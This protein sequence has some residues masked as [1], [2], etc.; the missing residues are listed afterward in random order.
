MFDNPSYWYNN[1]SSSS[2]LPPTAVKKN[3]R[4]SKKWK[5]AMLDGLERIALD[6]FEQNQIFVDYYRMIDGE[7]SFQELKEAIPQLSD[8][9]DLLDGVG[10]PTFLKHYDLIGIIVN[11]LVGILIDQKDI[12]HVIDTGEIAESEYIREKTKKL[13]GLITEKIQAGVNLAMAEAG[14]NPDKADFQSEEEQQQYIAQMQQII[15]GATPKDLQEELNKK[16]KTKGVQWANVTLDQDEEKFDLD[17]LDKDNFKDMLLTGRCFRN[18]KVNFDSYYPE[19]WD[20]INTFF[21]QTID[22]TYPQKGEYIGRLHFFSPTDV[23]NRYGEYLDSKIQEELLSGN[24]DWKNFVTDVNPGGISNAIKSNF[25]TRY[26]VPHANYF[27]YTYALNLQDNLDTPLGVYTDYKTGKESNRFLPNRYTDSNYIDSRRQQSLRRDVNLREDLCQVLEAYIIVYELVGFLTYE[28]E[29]GGVETAEVDEDILPDFL[30]DNNIKQSYKETLMDIQ[31][32]FEVNTLKWYY[33]PV[34]YEG[35]KIKSSN[36]KEDLYVYFKPC[37]YQ[38]KGDS[39]MFEVMLPVSGYVGKS[40]AKKIAPYQAGYNLAM[41]QTYSLMEKEMGKLFLLDI[42][43]IPS[44]FEQWGDSEE[45]LVHLRNIAKDVGIMPIATSGDSRKSQNTFNQFSTYDLTN[46]GQIASRRDMAEYYKNK[47]YEAI[48]INGSLLGSPTKYET[49]EG[50]KVSNNASM[51]QLSEIFKEFSLFRKNSLSIHLTVA[52]YCQGDGKDL[53]LMTTKSDSTIEFLKL[54]DPEFPLRRLGL[55]P[56]ADN[57][58]KKQLETL[59]QQILQ[60]NTLGNDILDLAELV[61]SDSYSEAVEMARLARVRMEQSVQQKQQADRQNIELQNQLA[62]ERAEK[63][64]ERQEISKDKDR[65]VKLEDARIEALGRYLDE[66]ATGAN[67]DVINKQA[68][69]AQRQLKIDS[70]ITK[71]VND[72]KIKEKKITEDSKIRMEQLKLKAEELRLKKEKMN[73]DRFIAVV[74]KN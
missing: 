30:K 64:Y 52:Q 56:S 63:E 51:A 27:D 58:K 11:A 69:R 73:N 4:E 43:F 20:P 72:I 19:R 7:M 29:N 49:A 33:K 65:V 68:D 39:N 23:I 61:G 9:Q 46:T 50:V 70:D 22:V 5:N 26:T 67:T 37:E 14:I 42:G 35:L 36:L 25:N 57:K 71:S 47:A 60:T 1:I 17:K 6:Q 41:N 28:N 2:Y 40:F 54:N 74:N 53:S 24:S 16:F 45:A 59:K 66:D 34:C 48:G 15:D 32:G 44:E 55:V 31:E 8:T 21:S 3:V 18:Y 10:I 13:R 62:E 38:I 12:F